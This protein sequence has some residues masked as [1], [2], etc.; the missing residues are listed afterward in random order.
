MEQ[1]SQETRPSREEL[2]Q[3]LRFHQM[4]GKMGRLKSESREAL[5]ERALQKVQAQQPDP[6]PSM[7]AASTTPVSIPPASGPFFNS[8]AVRT[9][10]EQL[11]NSISVPIQGTLVGDNNRDMMRG[12]SL[13]V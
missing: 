6:Q 10:Q 12:P 5:K 8:P 2:R 3:R 13:G 7:P 1:P 11:A 4:R 9:I